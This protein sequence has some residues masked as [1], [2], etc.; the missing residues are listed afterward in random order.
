MAEAKPNAPAA[1]PQ[2]PGGGDVPQSPAN[3][4]KAG[5]GPEDQKSTLD[6]GGDTEDVSKR[7]HPTPITEMAA[8]SNRTPTERR[9]AD[10]KRPVELAGQPGT[11]FSIRGSGFGNDKGRLTVSG[12]QIEVS[13]WTDESIKGTLPT[14]IESGEIVLRTAD[15]VERKGEYFVPGRRPETR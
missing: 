3:P 14:D 5:T 7:P 8:D 11:M 9:I 6:E 12:R 15:G 13:K 10:S 2:G 4:P 1:A